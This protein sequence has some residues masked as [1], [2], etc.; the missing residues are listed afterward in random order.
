[1]KAEIGSGMRVIGSAVF[2][3]I[4]LGC[5]PGGAPP[6]SLPAATAPVAVPLV[7]TDPQGTARPAGAPFFLRTVLKFVVPSSTDIE[8]AVD[9]LMV[10]ERSLVQCGDE[11][12]Y[13][14][15]AKSPDGNGQTTYVIEVT[16]PAYKRFAHQVKFA[17]T[18]VSLNASFTGSQLASKPLVLLILEAI[19]PVLGGP[20]AP[21]GVS[22]TPEWAAINGADFFAYRTTGLSSP[23]DASAYYQAIDPT[24]SKS[25]LTLWKQANGFAAN[26]DSQDDA[27]AS[28]F[29]AGDL[30]LGRS[31]HMKVNANSDVA[32]YVSN[33][34]TVEDAKRHTNLIATVGMEYAPGAPGGPRFAKF[35]VY[36]ADG[37]ITPSA[38]LDGNGQKFVPNLC[39]ICHGLNKYA[40]GSSAD[41]GAR[42]LPFDLASF[43]YDLVVG[44][45]GQEAQFRKLNLGILQTNKSVAENDLIHAWYRDPAQNPPELAS[46]VHNSDAVP[47]GWTGHDALYLKVIKPSCRACHVSRNAGLD[48]GTYADFEA[49]A[50][51]AQ[52]VVCTERMMPNAIVTY[53]K[54]WLQHLGPPAIN[55]AGVLN[56]SNVAHWDGTLHCP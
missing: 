36:A 45:N 42:F 27:S 20:P 37:S 56:Q 34:P 10:R 11:G 33:Y 23:Q 38:D 2:A 1:M 28:Y 55:Q 13:D 16:P 53:Q 12:C 30:G 3:A 7:A 8:V 14:V 4:F 35:Y 43:Q 54:F 6:P 9:G 26:D 52:R 41:I 50:A 18:D 32:Y 5:T 31:M 15:L 48:F 19:N 22:G 49:R 24:G 39:V 44:R 46:Q 17:V 40:A 21:A 47:G 25:T 51:T 29:N